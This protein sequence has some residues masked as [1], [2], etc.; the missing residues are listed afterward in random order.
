MSYQWCLVK[1]YKRVEAEDIEKL[2]VG[3]MVEGIFQTYIWF[4]FNGRYHL[5][6]ADSSV[7]LTEILYRECIKTHE[8]LEKLSNYLEAKKIKSRVRGTVATGCPVEMW[9]DD[10]ERLEYCNFISAETFK[11]VCGLEKA[12]EEARKVKIPEEKPIIIIPLK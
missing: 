9:E 1:E 4:E 2:S 12:L 3:E 6:I 8:M 10:G 11:P 7:V 5:C